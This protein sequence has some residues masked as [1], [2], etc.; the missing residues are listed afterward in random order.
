M[1]R[2]FITASRDTSIYEVF[3][4]INAG[5]DEIIEV[6]KHKDDL[7]DTNGIVRSL[8]YYDVSDL[9]GAP[10]SSQIVLSL[11]VANAEKLN[12]NEFVYVYPMSSSW[13]EGSGYYNQ[14]PYVSSDGATWRRYAT[15]S[16]WVA[17]GSDFNVT[18]V[19][20]ASLDNLSNDRFRIDVTDVVRPMISGSS[21]STNFGLLMKFANGS[22]SDNDNEGTVKFFS[23]NTHT[24]HEPVLELLWDAQTISAGTLKAL[25]NFDI[26]LAPNNLKSEY[27]KGE[28]F[29][30]YFTV[31]DKY[32]Q[33][34]YTNTN[35]FD[36]KYYLPT[37]SN[38]SITDIGSGTTV[39]Q[40]DDYSKVDADTNGSFITVD[41]TSLFKG[42]FYA[43]R[44]KVVL[45]TETYI[46]RTFEFKVS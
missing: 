24:I 38:F 25:V 2:V 34:V 32:P 37:A 44:L 27:T 4:N 26:E 21:P 29:K 43:I 40:F 15:G 11:G 33:K 22:E 14:T 13:D 20:S 10:T 42:R 7:G 18:P 1:S 28:V 39:I 35:R 30:L 41:T 45:N 12:Q 19:V 8:Q 16:F 5:Y 46:S 6:G 36:N 17:S 31:R 3:P 23:R 9:M